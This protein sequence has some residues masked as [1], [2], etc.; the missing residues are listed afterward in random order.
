MTW[1]IDASVALRWLLE[2]EEHPGAEAVL[3][4]MVGRPGVFAVPELFLFEVWAVLC[5]LHPNALDAFGQGILPVLQGGILRQPMTA[6]LA[7]AAM[8][9]VRLGL[10]GYD[11]CY[12]ALAEEFGGVWLTFDGK[13]HRRLAGESLSHDLASGMPAGWS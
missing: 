1:I 7:G 12:A 8:R 2:G 4:R 9:F 3:E 13:A 6:G 11:A 5:R 10:T